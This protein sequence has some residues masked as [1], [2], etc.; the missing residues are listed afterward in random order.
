MEET[1]FT[2]DAQKE[3]EQTGFI[4]N[5]TSKGILKVNRKYIEELKNLD[6]EKNLKKIS[7]PVLLIHG[8]V[9]DVV[10]VIQ[11]KE[12]F[13]ILKGPKKLEVIHNANHAWWNKEDT[14]LMK[15]AKEKAIKLSID[16]LKKWLR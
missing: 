16:W 11:S 2:N 15:E 7:C 1:F 6:L 9:D 10:P 8:D 14:K 13:N 3:L 4:R 12:T 5:L